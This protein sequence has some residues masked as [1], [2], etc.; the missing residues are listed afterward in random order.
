MV[1]VGTWEERPFDGIGLFS[2]DSSFVAVP[3]RPYDIRLLEPNT[4]RELARLADPNQDCPDH[5]AFTSDGGKLV[6][7]NDYGR[8]IHVWDLRAIRAQL[9]EMN[10][11]W[12]APPLPPAP[13]P[14]SEPLQIHIDLGDCN[15]L[16]EAASLVRQ[17]NKS[18]RAN[19]H[20]DA[21]T[22]LKKAVQIA[23]SHAAAQNNLA[24]LLLTG[25][26]GLRD[27]EQALRAAQK[28]VELEREQFIYLNTLGV[29]LYRNGKF[30]EAVPVL[31][32][33]LREQ[34]GQADAFDLFFLAMCH[35]RLGDATK[36]KDCR[37]RAADWFQKHKSQLAGSGWLQ[38]LTE[39]QAEAEQLLGIEKR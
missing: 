6:D 9:V 4:G 18:V 2:P 26:K 31:E 23:P 32:R 1:K 7:S 8:A 5:L 24:W 35:H 12:D 3:A 36:A 30:A 33:S 10:L 34:E 19:K 25:P 22:A 28:A 17:A 14:P 39:F 15:N 13:P 29:A 27:P 37:D 20:Q 11:D 38:E 16:A 21:L